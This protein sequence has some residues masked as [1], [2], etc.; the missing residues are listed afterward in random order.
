MNVIHKGKYTGANFKSLFNIRVEIKKGY[1]NK[2]INIENF[3]K[4]SNREY[5]SKSFEG[6][7]KKEK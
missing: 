5:Y 1:D 7:G 6:K 3:V 4:K 2:L